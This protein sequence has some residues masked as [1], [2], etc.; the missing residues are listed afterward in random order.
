MNKK[1]KSKYLKY[2]LVL[3]S[4]MFAVPSVIY[5]INNKTI[6]GFDREF[7]F[8]LT[9][10]GRLFQTFIYI[11]L[12]IGMIIIYYLIIKNKDKIF[13]D[14]KQILKYI[15]IIALIFVLVVPFMSSDVFY[16]LGTGRLYSEYGQNPYYGTIAGYTAQNK[17][18]DLQE[19][20]VLR[21]GNLNVWGGTTVVYGPIWTLICG[22]IAK[23]SLGNVDL[24]LLIFKLI[25]ALIHLANC[26]IIYKIWDKKTFTL[27]YGLNPFVLIEGISNAHND[28][29]V[30][31]F[32]LLATYMLVKKKSITG[33]LLFLSLAT[34]IKYFAILLLPI[35][36]IYHNR[37]KVVSK[38][39]FAGIACVLFF[40][41][42][43]LIYYLPFIKDVTVLQGLQT[44]QGRFAKSVYI[45]IKVL[46][47]TAK[48]ISTRINKILLITF[49]SIYFLK[50]LQ[51][52][53]K[54]KVNLEK[55]MR[56]HLIFLMIFL[57]L[58]I[59][60]FQPWYLIWVFYCIFWQKK[61]NI[62]Y[63]LNICF[64][65]LI[66]NSV[67]LIFSEMW[68]Y[69][70]IFSAIMIASIILLKPLGDKVKPIRRFYGEISIN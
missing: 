53:C 68:V 24:G 29:F 16:Y 36:I 33:A 27:M 15:C 54:K 48:G 13:K 5:Y 45:I 55:E 10:N 69:G 26:Y 20:T 52:L 57:F 46:F 60:N 49:I 8:L 43:M 38:R 7:Y 22:G 40:A 12:I 25:N 51:L 23:L 35:F 9:K 70:A 6:L 4:A 63:I 56:E 37:D 18:I 61:E 50:C 59:T 44:Q 64:M 42:L 39:I 66:A 14:N 1:V 19:D 30:L 47:P 34:G 41:S 67:F 62:F 32:I 11:Y 58:L 3:F 28:M 31:L 21:Q 2:L 17:E 65:S